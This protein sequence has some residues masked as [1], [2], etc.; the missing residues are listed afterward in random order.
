M[1]SFRDGLALLMVLAF[2]AALGVI[3]AAIVSVSMRGSLRISLDGDDALMDRLALD[4]EAVARQWLKNHGAAISTPVET[5][6]K[7]LLLFRNTT[8][9]THGTMAISAQIWDACAGI[10]VDDQGVMEGWESQIPGDIRAPSAGSPATCWLRCASTMR[11]VFPQM[12]PEP[13]NPP[14]VALLL[15]PY[16]DG[17]LNLRTAPPELVRHLAGDGPLAGWAEDMMAQRTRPGAVFSTAPRTNQRGR[18]LLTT[19]TDRWL[20]LTD[21]RLDGRQRRWWTVLFANDR[22]VTSQQR[23]AIP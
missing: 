23:Y 11:N 17:R 13:G 14:A 2:T 20:L 12:E 6:W 9:T 5:P 1:R 4:T 16:S 3:T 15:S 10:P 7:G 22:Q 8:E 18:A 21:I 19:T